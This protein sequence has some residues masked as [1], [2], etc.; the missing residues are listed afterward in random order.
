MKT[1]RY[2]HLCQWHQEAAVQEVNRKPLRAVAALLATLLAIASQAAF[3]QS[4]Q[5]PGLLKL[6]NQ[7]EPIRT[8]QVQSDNLGFPLQQGHRLQPTGTFDQKTQIALLQFE[9]YFGLKPSGVSAP[10]TSKVLWTRREIAL[11]DLLTQ[12]DAKS[13]HRGRKALVSMGATAVPAILPLL[14]HQNAF[15][16]IRAVAVLREIG[17]QAKASVPFLVPLLTDYSVSEVSTNDIKES[18][19]DEVIGALA[20]IDP[21][22][23]FAI[24]ALIKLLSSPIKDFR[25]EV[26]QTLSKIGAS[27]VPAL[28]QALNSKNSEVRYAAAFALGY[29]EPVNPSVT[30]RLMEVAKNAS[31]TLKVRQMAVFSL[32]MMGQNVQWYYG[33]KNQK[34]EST[35]PGEQPNTNSEKWLY[36]N[37][38]LRQC[39]KIQW[40]YA[41]DNSK[42]KAN[43]P[44][45]PNAKPMEQFV[46][47]QGTEQCTL[48]WRGG[49]GKGWATAFKRRGK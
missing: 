5:N 39:Q 40:Y 13:Y 25:L 19:S 27:T 1:L 21:D 43:C 31:E 6:G 44:I 8:L 18:V 42:I 26:A 47:S 9:Q 36:F 32:G 12:K 10:Q 33:E 34:V 16:R 49:G 45:D 48:G 30:N 17:P 29:I 15:V 38:W 22:A 14:Q 3:A 7:G 41:K 2:L 24:P 28:L 37:P 20:T 4:A 46:F 23:N 35:C 11:T